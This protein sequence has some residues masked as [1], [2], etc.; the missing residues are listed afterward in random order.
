[1]SVAFTLLI[2]TAVAM[3]SLVCAI[4]SLSMSTETL[5]VSL[6]MI[7]ATSPWSRGS[8]RGRNSDDDMDRSRHPS[9]PSS[10][11]SSSHVN[12]NGPI[13]GATSLSPS[14]TG[15][16]PMTMLRSGTTSSSDSED[17]YS[18]SPMSRSPSPTSSEGS[19][20]SG[21]RSAA[22][23]KIAGL[24]RVRSRDKGQGLSDWRVN[25]DTTLRDGVPHHLY[26]QPGYPGSS[27]PLDR[28]RHGQYTEWNNVQVPPAPPLPDSY[29]YAED[30]AADAMP[31]VSPPS[32]TWSAGSGV[33]L[34]SID[35]ANRAA[36]AFTESAWPP[37]EKNLQQWRAPPTMLRV[38]M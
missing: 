8:R 32:P 20:G 4:D 26:G 38:R 7:R 28:T 2:R 17:K 31:P 5:A 37:D 29:A 33:S 24:L 11:S 10:S 14:D 1:M 35:E 22:R 9:V 16:V 30:S 3:V 21:I 6:R 23:R 15:G 27:D 13:Y 12:L 19:T 18:W 36:L 25:L 34:A